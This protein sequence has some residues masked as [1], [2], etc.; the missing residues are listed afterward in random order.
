MRLLRGT[1]SEKKRNEEASRDQTWQ[2]QYC[3]KSAEYL[4]K[5]DIKVQ[6]VEIGTAG[7]RAHNLQ[8]AFGLK[9]IVS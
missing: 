6:A 7:T 1:K 8:V 2:K 5:K 4:H 9:C 3:R